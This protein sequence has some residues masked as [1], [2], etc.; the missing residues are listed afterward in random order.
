MGTKTWIERA[1]STRTWRRFTNSFV[2]DVECL[3]EAEEGCIRD[4]NTLTPREQEV[5]LEACANI[6]RRME[7]HYN[8]RLSRPTY[9][10]CEKP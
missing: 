3:I 9:Q 5:A 10:V 8:Y 1:L 2:L 6:R 4:G 7:G